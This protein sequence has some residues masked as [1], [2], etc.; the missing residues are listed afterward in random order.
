MIVNTKTKATMNWVN[1]TELLYPNW[2]LL[3]KELYDLERTLKGTTD[4]LHQSRRY[5]YPWVYFN[6]APW[7]PNDIVLDAGAGDT[8]FRYLLAKGVK[9]VCSIDIDI[10][11][12][13][14]AQGI[15]DKF[16]NVVPM[17]GDIMDIPF[18]D[19]Y[20]SKVYCISVLEHLPKELVKEGIDELLRVTGGKIAIT[21]DVSYERTDKQVDM[22]DFINLMKDYLVVPSL[23]S[24]SFIFWD[25]GVEPPFPFVV[26]CI[27]IEVG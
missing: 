13:A 2:F 20:F 15:R 8:V 9:K 22:E 25:R 12:V 21:M 18:S 23:S 10:S 4:A 11:C 3:T 26:A 19:N 5:E 16:V 24:S 14:W 1:T 27:L 17:V 6:L 7:N